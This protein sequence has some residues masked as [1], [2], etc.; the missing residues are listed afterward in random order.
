MRSRGVD[1]AIFRCSVTTAR[2]GPK[3]MVRERWVEGVRGGRA[4]SV[5][6][7]DVLRLCA[8][9]HGGSGVRRWY[10]ATTREMQ[11]ASKRPRHALSDGATS[12]EEMI[13]ERE[14]E[15]RRAGA[16]RRNDHWRAETNEREGCEQ[17]PGASWR[18]RAAE[19]GGGG[20]DGGD[21]EMAAGRGRVGSGWVGEMA[22]IRS[23]SSSKRRC[24]GWFA[25]V[26]RAPASHQ[27]KAQY[28]R[29]RATL[30]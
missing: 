26:V 9:D 28:R 29:R 19:G 8:S 15:Q 11:Y 22:G 20:G 12:K 5:Y 7:D 17:Y 4:S 16:A 10:G 23:G 2:T 21:D 13:L 30:A 18:R 6:Q 25:C 27:R 3:A 14:T 24:R 1:G